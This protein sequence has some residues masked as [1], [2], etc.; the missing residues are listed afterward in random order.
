[1]IILIDFRLGV[2]GTLDNFGFKLFKKEFEHRIQR[3]AKIEKKLKALGG[4]VDYEIRYKEDGT[5]YSYPTNIGDRWLAKY[6][7]KSMDYYNDYYNYYG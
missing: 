1:L 2:V 4:V 5:P 6:H 3:L 7:G